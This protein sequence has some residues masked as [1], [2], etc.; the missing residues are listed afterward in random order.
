MK[1][2]KYALRNKMRE[3]TA[4]IGRSLAHLGSIIL[5]PWRVRYEASNTK[6]AK[7]EVY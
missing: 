7:C 5:H 4:G 3:V 1:T 2:A 6:A